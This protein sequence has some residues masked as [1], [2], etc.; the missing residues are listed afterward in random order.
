MVI[1]QVKAKK[2]EVDE[3]KARVAEASRRFADLQKQADIEHGKAEAALKEYNEKETGELSS[4]CVCL[5]SSTLAVPWVCSVVPFSQRG[6][7]FKGEVNEAPFSFLYGAAD[8]CGKAEPDSVRT[9]RSNYTAQYSHK[10]LPT[11]LVY[12]FFW[13]FSRDACFG[14]SALMAAVLHAQM[15]PFWSLFHDKQPWTPV[16]P[17]IVCCSC[18]GHMHCMKAQSS[19]SNVRTVLVSVMQSLCRQL[20]GR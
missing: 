11:I 18:K 3:A 2:A 4:P 16:K 20:K 13:C 12:S 8:M 6:I 15:S 9:L 19:A 14:A 17:A 7:Q 5:C 10:G 1:L